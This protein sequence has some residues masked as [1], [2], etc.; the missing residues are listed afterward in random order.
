M[1]Q[2]VSWFTLYKNTLILSFFA[3]LAFNTML[4]FMY[5]KTFKGRYYLIIAKVNSENKKKMSANEC[6]VYEALFLINFYYVPR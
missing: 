1:L 5:L 3:L 4:R 2:H 6:T